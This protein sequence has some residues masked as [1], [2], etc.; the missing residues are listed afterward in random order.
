MLYYAFDLLFLDGFD[1]RAAPLIERR[2][3]LAELLPLKPGSPIL[4]SAHLEGQG[5]TIF[6]H[7]CAMGLE[8]LVCKLRDSPYGSG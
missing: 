3:V 2:R 4:F 8:G 5:E 1:L 6:D 7:A